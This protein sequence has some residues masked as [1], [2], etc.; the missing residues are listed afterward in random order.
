MRCGEEG[1]LLRSTTGLVVVEDCSLD[2]DATSLAGRL[3][4][5]FE[6]GDG[7]CQTGEHAKKCNGQLHRMSGRAG[8]VAAR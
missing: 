8:G 2:R 6:S 1:G 7:H 3:L 5:D 4:R